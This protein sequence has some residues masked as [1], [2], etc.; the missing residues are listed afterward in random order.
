MKITDASHLTDTELVTS[1]GRLTADERQATLALVIHL[2]EFDVRRL[3]EPAGF[4]SLFAYCRAVLQLLRRERYYPTAAAARPVAPI[5][6]QPRRRDC[7][8]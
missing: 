1:L 8:K 6:L 3:Y 7:S 2:A 5:R 4:Q